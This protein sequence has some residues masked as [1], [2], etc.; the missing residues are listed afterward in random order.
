MVVGHSFG[1]AEA[2]TFASLFA[3]E[4]TGLVLLDASPT[5]WPTEVCAVPDDGSDMAAQ[6]ALDL[7]RQGPTRPTTRNISTSTPPSPRSPASP[8]SAT[9]R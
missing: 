9:S 5:S 6:L 1:G 7:C 3:D 4:V 8:R 2:V